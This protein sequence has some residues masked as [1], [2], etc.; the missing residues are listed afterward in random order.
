MRHGGERA[1]IAGAGGGRVRYGG[2]GG[3]AAGGGRL[4]YGLEWAAIAG[5]GGASSHG[6]RFSVRQDKTTQQIHPGCLHRGEIIM[7]TEEKSA[8]STR[9]HKVREKGHLLKKE[10]PY[11]V[12]NKVAVQKERY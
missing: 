2:E 1:A 5:K 9:G 4:R 7:Y 10:R 11:P 3:A 6:R 12:H 8:R